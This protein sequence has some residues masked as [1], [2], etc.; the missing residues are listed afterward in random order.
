MVRSFEARVRPEKSAGDVVF[1]RLLREHRRQVLGKMAAGNSRLAGATLGP[2]E[3]H[4][5]RL[6]AR[7]AGAG[8]GEAR[9]VA[10]HVSAAREP[11]ISSDFAERPDGPIL[12]LPFS[13]PGKHP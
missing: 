3:G 13:K 5:T 7:A 2:R 1:A 6:A 9:G 12:P 8:K 10:S 4:M 11:V